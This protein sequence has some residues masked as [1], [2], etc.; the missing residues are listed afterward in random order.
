M[1]ILCVDNMAELQAAIDVFAEDVRRGLADVAQQAALDGAEHARAVGRFQD[2]SGSDGLR[3]SIH[4]WP[5]ERTAEGGRCQ[6][7][8]TKAYAACVEGGTVAHEIRPRRRKALAWEQGGE[9]VF[10]RRVTHPGTAPRPFMGPATIKAEAALYARA[11]QHVAACIGRA[12]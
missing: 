4:A 2:H 7:G 8:T 1:T 9:A 3:A 6:F 11:E 5:V 10:A 12:S